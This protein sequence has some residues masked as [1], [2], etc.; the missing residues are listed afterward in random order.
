MTLFVRFDNDSKKN[1]SYKNVRMFLCDM[2][3]E[4][5]YDGEK[6]E[7]LKLM[8]RNDKNWFSVNDVMDFEVM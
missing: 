4:K 6:Y 8:V 1:Q 2:Q 3:E 5:V 7:V